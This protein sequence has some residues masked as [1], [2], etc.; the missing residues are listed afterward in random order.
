MRRNMKKPMILSGRGIIIDSENRFFLSLRENNITLNIPGGKIEHGETIRECVIRELKQELRV[1]VEIIR[2]I[3]HI[4]YIPN[5]KIEAFYLVQITKGAPELTCE[6][7][8][9]DYYSIRE[10][11]ENT[12]PGHVEMLK[13]FFHAPHFTHCVRFK[14]STHDWILKNYGI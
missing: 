2:F 7:L 6:C 1:Q 8:A 12:I 13:R 9:Y 14:Q 10:I 5:K 11:P 3:G 4:Y